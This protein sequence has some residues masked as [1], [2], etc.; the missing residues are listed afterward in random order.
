MSEF[1]FPHFGA[2]VCNG[3]TFDRVGIGAVPRPST[4]G[5]F[6]AMMAPE[7][8]LSL[9]T[10]L[11]VPRP[12]LGWLGERVREGCAI[13]PPELAIRVSRGFSPAVSRHEGRHRMTLLR[14]LRAARV[15]VRISV[16]GHMDH[17]VSDGLVEAIRQGA[18]A[19]RGGPF[20]AGPLFDAAE[21]DLGG[22]RWTGIPPPGFRGTRG[23]P[24]SPADSGVR[25]RDA[26]GRIS[27]L[28]PGTGWRLCGQGRSAALRR[29]R[30]RRA[31]RPSS[32]PGIP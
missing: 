31:R 5:A 22:L 13:A 27:P 4:D 1:C 32:V 25:P 10:R 30:R 18:R 16:V 14:S 2:V 21:S 12:S 23:L 24:R 28:P 8:F 15:P 20:V 29:G 6:W 26:C 19:Q 7:T 11:P 9:A 17:E 3:V